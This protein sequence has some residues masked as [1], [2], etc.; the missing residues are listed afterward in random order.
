MNETAAKSPTRRKPRADGLRNREHLIDVA[1]TAFT[2]VGAAV[3]LEEI[4]RRAEVGI[5]TLYRHFPTRDAIIEAVY[6]HEVERLGDA[7]TEF[8]KTKAPVDALRDWMR[9][10]VGH[11][12]AKKL[13]APALNEMVGGPSEL[14]AS[15][16]QRMKTAITSLVDRAVASGD[17]RLG[18]EPLDLLR[19]LAGV[20]NVGGGADWEPSALRL[21]DILIAGVLVRR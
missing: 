5:G 12:T 16:T 3:T 14:Y 13:I 2:E 17:I 6:R 21:I 18:L 9:L 15:S 11:I 8:A 7:A 19:A 4:A 20:A 1:K 10:F